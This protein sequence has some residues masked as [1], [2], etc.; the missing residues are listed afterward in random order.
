MVSVIESE[1]I[2]GNYRREKLRGY[3]LW[4]LSGY[5]QKE[6]SSPRLTFST[7]YALLK[8]GWKVCGGGWPKP[9]MCG[10]PEVGGD[11]CV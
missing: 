8:G 9:I 5:L 10:S 4:F 2:S 1:L 11:L 7:T 6:L 3:F